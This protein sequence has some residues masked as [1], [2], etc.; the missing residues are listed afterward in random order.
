MSCADML[1]NRLI[2]KKT[3]HELWN[4]KQPNIEFFHPFLCKCFIHNNGKDNIDM[5]DARSNEG[6]FFWYSNSIRSYRI[7]NKSTLYNKESVHFVFDDTN[8]SIETIKNLLMKKFHSLYRVTRKQ[9]VL[10]KSTTEKQHVDPIVETYPNEWR[11]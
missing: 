2:L 8:K 4:G 3:P 7:F 10:K 9:T 5:F 11:R 1:L 6:I